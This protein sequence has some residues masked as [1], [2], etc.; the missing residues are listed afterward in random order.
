M[1]TGVE[2]FMWFLWALGVQRVGFAV[3]LVTQGIKVPVAQ[4]IV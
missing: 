4:Q 2:N 1:K 3:L